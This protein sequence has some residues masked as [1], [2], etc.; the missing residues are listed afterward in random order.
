M[1]ERIERH[2]LEILEQGYTVIPNVLDAAQLATARTALDHIFLAEADIGLKRN[3]HN[4]IYK[5]AYMLPQKHP[6]FRAMAM[7]PRLLPMIQR[8]LGDDCN[9]S[10]INGL[11]MTPGGDFQKL[12][13][14]AFQSTPGL[15]VYINALHCLDDFTLANGATRLVPGSHMQIWKNGNIPPEIESQ[16]VSMTASA[17]SVIAYNGAL[18]HAGSRNTTASPRRAVHLYFHRSWAK[19]QWDMPR[20]LTPEVL[21]KMD[22]EEK[23]LY[24]YDNMPLIY[25]VNS[26]RIVQPGSACRSHLPY[27]LVPGG[28]RYCI[29]RWTRRLL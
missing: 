6:C 1:S 12:H 26:H 10:N 22:A 16:A 4:N 3:W 25:D 13:M 8:V 2:V 29:Q 5:V 27:R 21:A 18:L 28:F 20:S 14:D 15:C 23:R 9:L 24:G 11:A 19:P 17:G 7:N